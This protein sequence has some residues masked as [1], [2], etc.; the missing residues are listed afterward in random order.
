VTVAYVALGL[1]VLSIAWNVWSYFHSRRFDVRVTVR[2]EGV[3]VRLEGETP[4]YQLTVVVTNHGSTT[5]FI[6]RVGLEFIDETAEEMGISGVS[7]QVDKELA[8][9]QNFRWTWDLGQQRYAVGRKYVG[10]ASL[11]RGGG[12]LEAEPDEFDAYS[13]AIAGLT[14][15]VR[16]VVTPAEAAA[17]KPS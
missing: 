13:L 12:R 7:K 4:E 15:A 11:A 16:P 9:N 6:E 14:Q 8:P 17:A 1:S 3:P 5:E 10:T 2:S